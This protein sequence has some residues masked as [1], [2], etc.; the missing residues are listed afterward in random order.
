[1]FAITFDMVVADIRKHYP[2]GIS[3]AYTEIG[4]TLH[5]FGFEWVQGSVYVT[6]N[7]DMGNLFHAI[8]ALK[9]KPWFSLCVRDVRGFRAENWSNF[10]SVVKE[11]P[12]P[13][14]RRGS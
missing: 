13:T 6:R 8:N 14:G 9:A 11:P 10:T 3:S 4:Q 1:M 12:P 7:P 2:K 5:P